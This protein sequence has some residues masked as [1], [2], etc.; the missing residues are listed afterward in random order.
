MAGHY[1]LTKV[2]SGVYPL[3]GIMAFAV[4]GAGYFV[5]HKTSGPD[6]VWARKSNPQPW[7]TVQAN[8][9]TKIYDP[10]GKFDKWSR[11]SA[12]S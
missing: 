7:N 1:T 5:V 8:Q 10:S 6:C 12:S 9:T 2:P 11:F 3:F 4:A